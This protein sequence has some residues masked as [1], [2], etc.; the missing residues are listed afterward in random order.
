MTIELLKNAIELGPVRNTSLIEIR[1]FSDRP[2]EAA[3]IANTIA[4]GVPRTPAGN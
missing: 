3:R 2:E 1:V 4:A